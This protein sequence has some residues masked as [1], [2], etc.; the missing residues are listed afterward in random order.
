MGSK[1]MPGKYMKWKALA[2]YVYNAT[3][4]MALRDIGFAD[5]TAMKKELIPRKQLAPKGATIVPAATSGDEKVCSTV[6]PL[7]IAECQKLCLLIINK[8]AVI[9]KRP[10]FRGKKKKRALELKK[11]QL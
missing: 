9:F 1:N 8:G 11:M 5:K 6:F 10:D 2:T 3:K 7:V 4:G